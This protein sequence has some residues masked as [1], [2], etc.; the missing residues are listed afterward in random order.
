MGDY[1]CNKKLII[2]YQTSNFSK[3]GF[4]VSKISHGGP[5]NGNFVEKIFFAPRRN[6]CG[7]IYRFFKNFSYRHFLVGFLIYIEDQFPSF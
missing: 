2:G 5:K 1:S 7:K 4:Q 6:F 3:I